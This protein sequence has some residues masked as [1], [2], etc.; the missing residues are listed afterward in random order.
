VPYDLLRGVWKAVRYFRL[1]DI[2]QCYFGLRYETAFRF[3]KRNL[4]KSCRNFYD[5]ISLTTYPYSSLFI[6]NYLSEWSGV[7]GTLVIRFD[8]GIDALSLSLKIKGLLKPMYAVIKI[9]NVLVNLILAFFF[10]YIPQLVK[11]SPNGF[12]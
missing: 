1:H 11:T 7:D 5:F 8:S 4:I 10:T 2:L 3:Y 9:G 12:T 6:C